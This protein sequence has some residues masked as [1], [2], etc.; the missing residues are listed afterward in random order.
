MAVHLGPPVNSAQ[1][2]CG[3]AQ[4]AGGHYLITG[5]LLLSP[6]FPKL[7]GS[8]SLHLRQTKEAAASFSRAPAK[9]GDQTEAV[10]LMEQQPGA[11]TKRWEQRMSLAGDKAPAS[12]L[13]AAMAF[14][15]GLC[16]LLRGPG[17]RIL[18]PGLHLHQPVP[19]G[20]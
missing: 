6:R 10:A 17:V 7:P 12:A 18:S 9:G 14:L 19:P 20:R 16:L 15:I 3:A 2:P 11:G 13:L 1:V 5:Q 8:E 4:Q